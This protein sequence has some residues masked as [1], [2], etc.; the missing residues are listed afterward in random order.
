MFFSRGTALANLALPLM[1]L[2]HQSPVVAAEIVAHR[3]A[4]A[5]APEN[6]IA[7]FRAAQPYAD[8]IEFDVRVSADGELVVIHDADVDRTTNGT[9]PVS[10]KTLA[11]LK[12]LDAGSWFGPLF[13]GQRIP[14]LAE[15]LTEVQP[16]ALVEHKAGTPAQ[17]ALVMPPD[18]GSHVKIMSTDWTFVDEFSELRP[19]ILVGALGG[20]GGICGDLHPSACMNSERLAEIADRIP[21]A[22]F[23]GW[24][25]EDLG[26]QDAA[27]ARAAGYTLYGWTV[28]MND[29]RSVD[30]ALALDLDGVI[31]DDPETAQLSFGSL[32]PE[33]AFLT[34]G[35]T[36]LRISNDPDLI[37]Y[38]TVEDFWANADTGGEEWG[39]VNYGKPPAAYEHDGWFSLGGAI[40]RTTNGE[41]L[42]IEYPSVADFITNQGTVLATIPDVADDEWFVFEEML[43][44]VTSPT[45]T[46][47]AYN[48][49]DDV[50]A[51]TG[52]ILGVVS[53]YAHDGWFSVDST[54]YRIGNSAGDIIEY[55]SLD[56][57]LANDG[58]VIG[59]HD[60]YADDGWFVVPEPSDYLGIGVGVGM[61]LVLARRRLPRAAS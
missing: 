48:A 53:N 16:T 1:F 19:D 56:D 18:S 38:D 50:I 3:G 26:R 25:I 43:Y 27:L 13:F 8:R 7:A 45:G 24:H 52:T 47:V 40:Y 14:T 33:T 54:I 36:I 35:Y 57:F 15:A 11:E 59:T 37:A 61:L 6:T 12:A 28:R 4:E 2:V 32:V 9:G 17:Y 23:I 58:T 5:V 20:T 39:K 29:Q 60:T 41:E 44:R 10:G 22:T 46:I 30:D 42:L 34:P 21:A 31:T 51:E 55:T 49:V